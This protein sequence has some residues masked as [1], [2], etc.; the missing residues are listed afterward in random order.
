MYNITCSD[1]KGVTPFNDDKTK[2]LDSL[3]NEYNNSDD[4]DDIDCRNYE[5]S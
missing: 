1:L 5:Q 2:Y 3:L 4:D